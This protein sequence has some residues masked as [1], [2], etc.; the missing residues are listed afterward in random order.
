MGDLNARVGRS[1]SEADSEF[2]AERSNT[3]GPWSLKGDIVPNANGSLLIDVAGE[4]DYRHFHRI[5]LFG[6]LSDGLGS[7][8]ALTLERYLTIYMCQALKCVM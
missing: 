4:N 8:P 6:I 7:T 2:G 1:T 3:V 5:L